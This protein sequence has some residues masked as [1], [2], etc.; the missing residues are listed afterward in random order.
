MDA[1]VPLEVI[2]QLRGAAMDGP[3]L[4]CYDGSE[5]SKAAREIDA[6]LIVCGQ[7]ARGAF[8]NA[9]LGSVS[10]QLSA[11]AERPVLTA[12]RHPAA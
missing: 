1:L 6:R 8:A 9:V 2:C 4:F 7:R 12:P 5:G 10:H 11:H 3:V